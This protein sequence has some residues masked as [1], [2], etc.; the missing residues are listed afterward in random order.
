MIIYLLTFVSNNKRAERFF[1]YSR[2]FIDF[3]TKSTLLGADLF[4]LILKCLNLYA[5]VEKIASFN[6]LSVL[7][8]FQALT[9]SPKTEYFFKIRS[10]L[11]KTNLFDNSEVIDFFCPLICY[12][13][14]STFW[15]SG[16]AFFA[17]KAD[18]VWPG[19]VRWLILHKN[20]EKV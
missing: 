8:M 5:S 11:L 15:R 2:C 10:E 12:W 13:E 9:F 7:I 19:S 16:F 17:V 1:L 20:T 14:Q 4:F 18:N 6:S 3:E